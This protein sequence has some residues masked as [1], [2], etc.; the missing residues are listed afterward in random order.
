MFVEVETESSKCSNNA[1]G[2]NKHFSLSALDE[3][4]CNFYTKLFTVAEQD[5]MNSLMPEYRRLLPKES[6]KQVI[7]CHFNF[8]DISN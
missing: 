3:D 2:K 7:I 5:C 1:F 8:I 6:S 4:I